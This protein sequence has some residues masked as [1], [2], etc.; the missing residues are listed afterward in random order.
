MFGSVYQ[1]GEHLY[2]FARDGV[3]LMFY[4]AMQR[5]ERAA[6]PHQELPQDAKET[7]Q[8]I[9]RIAGSTVEFSYYAS[10]ACWY[11]TAFNVVCHLFTRLFSTV[12]LTY[13]VTSAFFGFLASDFAN[14]HREAQAIQRK[15]L[16]IQ[17]P[18]RY[19]GDIEEGMQA[20]LN[21]QNV[22]VSNALTKTH[23]QDI[24]NHIDTLYESIYIL[25]YPLLIPL[26]KVSEHLKSIR[27]GL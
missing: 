23:L 3:D 14:L 7:I 21:I 25:K 9:N 4:E 18:D 20:S 27:Q 22:D 2:T 11:F 1:F 13:F 26:E 17:G 12:A 19:L 5:D 10:K 24:N 8:K 6:K 15:C 16:L